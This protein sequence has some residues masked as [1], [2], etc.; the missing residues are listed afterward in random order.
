METLKDYMIDCFDGYGEDGFLDACRDIANHGCSGGF[1]GFTYYSETVAVY[2][3][4]EDEIWAML[5]DDAKDQG[6]TPLELVASFN[7]AKD[8]QSDDQFRNLVVWY[9]VE[10]VAN[11]ELNAIEV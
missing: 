10:R 4:Y 3:T 1:N 11:Q 7:G 6:I 9:A 5:Y 2:S 8:V